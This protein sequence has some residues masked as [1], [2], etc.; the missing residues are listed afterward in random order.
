MNV[1]DNERAKP[2]SQGNAISVIVRWSS[3]GGGGEKRFTETFVAGRSTECAIQFHDHAVSRKHLE[4]RFENGVWSVIDL[5]SANGTFLDG[6]KVQVK[7]LPD[8]AVIELGIGGPKLELEVERRKERTPAAAPG[9]SSET[10]I[11]KRYFDRDDSAPAGEQTM[12]FRRA[13][14]Q[15]HKKKSRKYLVMI[16]F[17][18]VLLAV[19]AGVIVFQKKKIQ[20]L[21]AS[22]EAIFYS[23]KSLELQVSRLEDAILLT[24][25]P[26]QVA[27]LNAKRE[28]FKGMEKE[29]DNFIKELG[30][31]AKLSEEDRVILKVARMFGECEVNMPKGFVDEVK[32]YI[33]VWKSSGRLKAALNRAEQK[34]YAPLIIRILHDQNVPAQYLF[35]A[36]QESNFDERAV[37]PPTR[38]GHAKGMWQFIPQTATLYGLKIGPLF[39]KGVYDAADERFDYVKET[40]AAAKYIRDMNNTNAQASGLLVMASYNWGESN[41]RQIIDKMP[42]NP[43]ERN[44]WRLIA[45]KNIPK[46]TYDYVYSIFSAAVIC[47]NPGLFKVDC[48]CP[49]LKSGD[50]T[51]GG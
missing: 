12:M 9:F 21:R 30:T 51:T 27:E 45:M 22:A 4:V 43:R 36:L 10:Q 35:L 49:V 15:V 28:K 7:A 11:I 50:K 42:D 14:D 23:M 19:A 3:T 24:A 29:Y 40:V 26:K 1:K 5:E 17:A 37:G 38:F 34:G 13:F 6:E 2:V 20:A 41:V 47:E 8:H 39:E 16:S 33:G 32:K 48:N 46:E 31:Y 18:T 44:F 25:D